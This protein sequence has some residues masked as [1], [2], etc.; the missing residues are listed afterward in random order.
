MYTRLP[1]EYSSM[2]FAP[3]APLP[4]SSSIETTY[5]F[6]NRELSRKSNVALLLRRSL[7]NFSALALVN[8][9]NGGAYRQ[10]QQKTR[11]SNAALLLPH[12]SPVSPLLRYS[13]KK[14]GG[15]P[16]PVVFGPSLTDSCTTCTLDLK[17]AARPNRI[18]VCMALP[19]RGRRN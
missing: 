18:Q 10:I 2:G 19:T 9:V 8:Q 17:D 6:P 15:T 11:K 7:H 4:L 16:L 1:F 14:M 3:E 12:V 5:L 13:Y